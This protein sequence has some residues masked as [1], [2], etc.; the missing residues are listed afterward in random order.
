MYKNIPSARSE[1]L[2]VASSAAS[3]IICL[4]IYPDLEECEVKSIIEL[5]WTEM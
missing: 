3:K 1:N 4:P 5:I 2:P